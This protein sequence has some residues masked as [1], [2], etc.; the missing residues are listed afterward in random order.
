MALKRQ[1]VRVPPAPPSIAFVFSASP[2]YFQRYHSIDDQD[3]KLRLHVLCR[4]FAVN[5]RAFVK[6]LAIGIPERVD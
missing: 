2:C 3:G 5:Y 4:D 6:S 1:G